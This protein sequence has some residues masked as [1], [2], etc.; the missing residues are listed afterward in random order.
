MNDILD[1]DRRPSTYAPV[2]CILRFTITRIHTVRQKWICSFASSFRRLELVGKENPRI[3]QGRKSE[4]YEYRMVKRKPEGS[5][6]VSSKIIF[7][8]LRAE[9]GRRYEFRMVERKPEGSVIVSSKIIFAEVRRKSEYS[10]LSFAKD[11]VRKFRSFASSG[12]TTAL[13]ASYG[14]LDIRSSGG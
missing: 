12:N 13:R 1:A 2:Y 4:R 14:L 7:D 8:K 3:C 9:V 10:H 11:S 5:V 6:I